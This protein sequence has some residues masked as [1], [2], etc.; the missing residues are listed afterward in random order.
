LE[1][2]STLN[3]MVWG[4]KTSF[5]DILEE[6]LKMLT[7]IAI[8]T[9]IVQPLINSVFGN[10]SGASTALDSLF[11]TSPGLFAKGAAFMGGSVVPFA[12]GGIVTKPTFFPMAKGMGLM[13]EA[14]PEAVMPLTRTSSGKLGVQSVGNNQPIQQNIK[15]EIINEGPEQV[16]VKSS[17]MSED[18][19]G[20]VL[21]IVIDGYSRNKYGMRD[22]FNSK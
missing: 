17:Q 8:Q 22:I 19:S 4:A 11:V 6:F 13:G 15:I 16:R 20:Q 21:Q 5:K 3:E 2:G 14:G 10:R 9:Q 18:P 12:T 1:F 7:E